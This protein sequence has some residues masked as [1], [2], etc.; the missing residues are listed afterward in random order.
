MWCLT[1]VGK[2][3]GNP[4]KSDVSTLVSGNGKH[5]SLIPIIGGELLTWIRLPCAL[6]RCSSVI[7]GNET[8]LFCNILVLTFAYRL[9]HLLI[10]VK[11]VYYCLAIEFPIMIWSHSNLIATYCQRALLVGPLEYRKIVF[12][13]E[14]KLNCTLL[15]I[16]E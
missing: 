10:L 9:I 11:S 14:C 2:S 3:K 5:L 15:I 6:A 1:N 7:R 8:W 12:I 4:M 16:H 13:Y